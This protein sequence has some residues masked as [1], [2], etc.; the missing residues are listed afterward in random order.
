M[1]TA[2]IRIVAYCLI[3]LSTVFVP[4]QGHSDYESSMETGRPKIGLVLSGG[5][6]LGLA[7]IGVLQVLEELHVPVDC[8]AGTSMGALVGGT[9]AAGVSPEH[10]QRVI[11]ETDLAALF[12]D[13]PP[14][15]D[16]A[17]LIKRNDYRPLFNFTLG[18]NDGIRL[19]SGASAGYKFELFLKQLIGMGASVSDMDFDD[20][21]VP[22][23][24]VATDLESGEMKVF[25][26]GDLSRIMRASMSLPGI[27]APEVIEDRVYVDGGL[28]RNLPVDIARDLCGDIIIAVNLGTAP[29]PREQINSSIDV[30]V[31]SIVLLTEQNV[32]RSLQELTSDDVLIVPDLEEFDSSTFNQPREII[33]RGVLAARTQADSLSRLAVSAD[34]YQAWQAA[35]AAKSPAPLSITAITAKTTGV[36][37]AQAVLRDID[38]ATGEAF[39]VGELDREIVNLYGRG[40]FAYVG[41]SIIPDGD[42]GII[43][44]DAQSKPWGPGYLKFGLGAA[45]DFSSPTQLNLAASYR[46]TW[47]NSL[48][49]EWRTDAQIGYDSFVNT[50]FIQPMQ[51]R[52]G[53]FVAPYIG[54][55]RYFVQFYQDEIRLGQF[56]VNRQDAGVDFGITG[57]AGELRLGP[58]ISRIRGRPDFG[59]AT[60]LVDETDAKQTGVAFRA[61]YDQLDSAVFPRAGLFG[62]LDI[63]AASEMEAGKD[64]SFTRAQAY[65]TA[66]KSIDRHTFSLHAEWGD[67]LTGLGDLPV[68]EVFKLGGPERLSGLYLD[69]LTGRR[70]QLATLSYYQQYASLPAQLGRG[71]Y[72]GLSLETGRIDDP[73][74]AQPW[75]WINGGSVFWGANT[76]LGSAY[77][78]YGRSSLDQSTWYLV[79]GPRF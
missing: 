37:N 43:Q 71:L 11:S 79:I 19:P 4:R 50:Q 22:Y 45:T 63:H 74:M 2:S 12:D 56:L 29:K 35:R 18:Y 47:L 39:D 69:Q 14:R 66:V 24:A 75:D 46:Q 58:Y 67:E 51:I 42:T 27:I 10:I 20:L 72:V 52:D 8:V 30:A 40:D 3:L 17:E 68:Y 49:A 78:G 6:A 9:W 5:G 65:L 23:R 15:S 57:R 54:A 59:V 1:R 73:F 44:I 41:Y 16:I 60:P 32:G 64:V 21:P 62:T 77:L 61:V 70:Y 34:A 33:E 38:S 13:D 7:H 28:V 26:H 55:R 53:A 36:V 25:S 76:V 31:Q 48:G